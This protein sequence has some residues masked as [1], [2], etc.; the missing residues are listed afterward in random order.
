MNETTTDSEL[1]AKAKTNGFVSNGHVPAAEHQSTTVVTN[2]HCNGVNKINVSFV[3]F[4]FCFENKKDVTFYR[5][6]KLL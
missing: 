2:G 1:C 5:K 6:W 4:M 3:L